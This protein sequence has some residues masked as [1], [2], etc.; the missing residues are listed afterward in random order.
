MKLRGNAMRTLCLGLLMSW[1]ALAAD[2]TGKWTAVF[3]TQIGEQKYTFELKASGKS[4][5]GR[6]NHA[7]GGSA[8]A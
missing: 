3:D 4:L 2:A 8:I 5:T 1:L 7:A 6:A